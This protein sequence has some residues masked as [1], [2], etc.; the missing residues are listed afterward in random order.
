M[1]IKLPPTG[2][3]GARRRPS[4]LD[5]SRLFARLFRRRAAVLPHNA[6]EHLDVQ[7]RGMSVGHCRVFEELR[8]PPPH[9]RA[10]KSR[11]RSFE[12]SFADVAQPTAEVIPV[13]VHDASSQIS[14]FSKNRGSLFKFAP[15]P[16]GAQHFS[17]SSRPGASCGGPQHEETSQFT[18]G[19]LRRG[20]GP[21][22]RIRR[23]LPKTSAIKLVMRS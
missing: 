6:L 22:E 3:S 16:I 2:T 10:P 14:F 13:H 7:R 8:L 17:A 18:R 23:A 19:I 12:K 11:W 4:A 9:S 21:D 15:D 1:A 20:Q 5:L